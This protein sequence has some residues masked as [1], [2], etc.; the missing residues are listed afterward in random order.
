MAHKNPICGYETPPPL[1]LGPCP[2]PPRVATSSVALIAPLPMPIASLK[3]ETE[4]EGEEKH[5][6]EIKTEVKGLEDQVED[7][8][9]TWNPPTPFG[10]DATS[11][12][13]YK[14]LE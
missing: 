8:E 2:S 13:T 3:S 1:E 6:D 7:E 11:L 4:N 12:H 5:I 10:S 14:V 9:I